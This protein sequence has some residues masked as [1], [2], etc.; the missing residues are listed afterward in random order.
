[1]ISRILSSIAALAVFVLSL[2]APS[3]VSAQNFPS[4]PVKIVVAVGAG[5]SPDVIGRIVAD[6]LTRIWGQQ[7]QALIINQPGAAG[8]IAIRAVGNAPPDGHTLYLALASNFIALPDMQANLPFDVA[9]DFVPIGFI[10]EQP[11]GIAASAAL[12]VNTLAE[13]VAYA[14][15]HPGELNVAAG[16]RGSILHFTAEWLRTAIG[17]DMTLLHYP[18]APQ[19]LADVLGGRVHL[20]VDALSSMRGAMAGGKIKVLAQAS[21]Q[22][23]PNFPDL[24]TAAETI[25]G[26]EGI[27]WIALVAP[28]GTPAPIA[29]KISADLR[30]V[31]QL[32]EVRDR[33]ADLGT[34][35]RPMS[36][37]ELLSFIHA[38]QKA[39]GP[40]IAATA[41]TIK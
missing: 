18:A 8:A 11:M 29:Q 24:P 7:A 2:T 13:L 39:W 15:K 20:M 28:P 12:G 9:R 36:G 1:M 41:K 38:Q 6:H 4:G 31:M 26:F 34:Y 5:S 17:V 30:T 33:L 16:N 40:I 14:K 21:L 10:G 3:V 32:P 19:A 35:A 27:G 25:P 22:R 23:L 37:G